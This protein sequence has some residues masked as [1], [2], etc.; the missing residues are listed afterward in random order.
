MEKNACDIEAHVPE[1]RHT[2]LWP[3]V[4]EPGGHC[5]CPG[6]GRDRSVQ[7]GKLRT[8]TRKRTCTQKVSS[9]AA[10]REEK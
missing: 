8:E 1:E 10:A 5:W 2:V 7:P 3:R 6:S 4:R 9:P